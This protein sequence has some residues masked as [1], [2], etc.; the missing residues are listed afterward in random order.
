MKK[1]P[2][3]GHIHPAKKGLIEQAA[4]GTLFLD[5]IGDLDL[6][7]QAKLLRF[8]E[9]GEFYKVGGTK[10]VHVQTRV[11]SAT[12]KNLL[13]MIDAGTF[14]EDLFF[15]IGVIKLEVPS[16]NNRPE[17]ILPIAKHFLV[18][19]C[20]K[21]GKSLSGITREAE[22]ALQHMQWRGN[23]RELKN[24]IER[25]TL[26][27]K[28]PKLTIEDIGGR[29]TCPTHC[30]LLPDQLSVMIPEEGIDLPSRLAAIE[31]Q[32]ITEAL[33]MTANNETSAAKLLHCKYST[34][35]YRRRILSIP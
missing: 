22:Q 28:G 20:Q 34:L 14:R 33:R 5:E 32:Y 16:L 19:F 23:I 12:N 26:I 9:S 35:R 27:A 4:D 6:A 1:G 2:S 15:R 3:A 8:L 18:E 24:I 10:A 21:F 25:A 30:Q 17:D 11:V 7:A 13:K 31:K 29:Q